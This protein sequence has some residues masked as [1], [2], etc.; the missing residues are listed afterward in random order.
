MMIVL[1]PRVPGQPMTFSIATNINSSDR[2]M[3]TSGIT[4]GAVIRVV[5]AVRPR[6]RPKRAST[7]P[8]S[9]PRTTAPVA[10]ITAICSE[11]LA[12]ERIWSL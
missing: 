3:I 10:L 6:N 1:I 9:V 4:S 5:N 2:P 8:A 12:A 7:N 11:R